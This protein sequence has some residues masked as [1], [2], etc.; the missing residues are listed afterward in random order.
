MEFLILKL[1][2]PIELPIDFKVCCS[3]HSL[4][5][6]CWEFNFFKRIGLYKDRSTTKVTDFFLTG[7]L[8]P[9]CS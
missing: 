6:L 4:C 9:S 8:E 7:Y 3:L 5:W 1:N 2:Y